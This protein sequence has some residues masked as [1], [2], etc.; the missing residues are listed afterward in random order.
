MPRPFERTL[1]T[2]TE[3][4]SVSFF[5]WEKKCRKVTE[6]RLAWADKH[7]R[8]QKNLMRFNRTRFEMKCLFSGESRVTSNMT[9]T[10]MHAIARL[11][12]RS[13]WD[14]FTTSFENLST[15]LWRD[16]PYL[17]IPSPSISSR[18]LKIELTVKERKLLKLYT[19]SLLYWRQF[20]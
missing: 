6:I 19:K 17:D 10:S 13:S 18:L 12:L 4:T 11:T 1:T 16:N 2:E 14:C 9:W 3:T 5:Y 15:F 20:Q 7:Q 8:W